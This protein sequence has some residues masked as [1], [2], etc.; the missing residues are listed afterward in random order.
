MLKHYVEFSYPGAF[1]S[2]H[3][4]KEIAERKPELVNAP[5]DA[6]AYRFYDREEV[7]VDGELLCGERKNFSAFTYFG[8]V[9]SLEEVKAEF[10]QYTTL[11]NNMECNGWNKVVRTRRGNWQPLGEGDIVIE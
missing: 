10:P 2:E 7:E 1:F 5:E 9:Y 6:F 8:K 4:I 11:I 3:S